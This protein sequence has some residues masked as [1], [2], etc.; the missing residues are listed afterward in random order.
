M[1]KRIAKFAVYK[2]NGV[3]KEIK[4]IGTDLLAPTNRKESLYGTLQR[5]HV[6]PTVARRA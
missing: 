4:Q 3:V 6:N 1:E 2:E 5:H